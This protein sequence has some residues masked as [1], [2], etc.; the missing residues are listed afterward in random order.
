MMPQLLR[1]RL[2]PKAMKKVRAG[3]SGVRGGR[4]WGVLD[5]GGRARPP[6]PSP[7]FQR[8]VFPVAPERGRGLAGS[9][10]PRWFF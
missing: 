7:I 6:A 10:A 2:S 8:P 5:R 3:R 9:R 4:V 1:W